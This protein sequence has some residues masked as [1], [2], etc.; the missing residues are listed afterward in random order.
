MTARRWLPGVLGLAALAAGGCADP[1][2]RCDAPQVAALAVA[3]RKLVGA[4]SPYP[5]DG[6]LR[7][8]EHE[9]ATSMAARRAA[10]WAAV[11]RVLEPVPFAIDPPSDVPAQ[12]P[13][14]QTWYGQ[15]DLHRM[16]QRLFRG[17][18]PDEQ[19]ARAP[20][21]DGALDEAF[22]WNPHAVDELDTWPAERWQAYVASLDTQAEVAGVGGI[23]RVAYSP[24]AAR[25]LMA[26]YAQALACKE[27]GTPP[28]IGDAPTAGPVRMA[29]ETMELGAC[30]ERSFGPYFVG[31]GETLTASVDGAATVELRASG[32]SPDVQA[33]PAGDPSC[34]DARCTAAGPAAVWLTVHATDRGAAALTVD[35]HEADPTWAP[36]LAAPFPLDAAVIKADWRRAE[37]GIL[38]PRFD[39]SADGLQRMID[40]ESTWGDGDAQLDPGP[41]EI[42]TLALPSNGARYR[43]T[44]LHLMTKELDHWLW[45][46]LW[47]SADPDHDFGADRPDAIAALPG[48]WRHYKMC[49]VTAFRDEDLDAAGGSA[50]ESLAKALAKVYT[51]GGASWCS[52]P[53]IELGHGNGESNC[54]GC[55]QHGGTTLDSA[56]IIGDED[57]F[58]DHA[59]GQERNNFPSDYSWAVSQGDHLGQMFADEVLFST[60]P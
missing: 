30:E 35:Y 39:T 41:D 37:L 4:A 58:P 55:H 57:H 34:D 33:P 54:I 56:T 18:T 60:P 10:A 21:T 2:P 16:F 59:R 14:W 50:D 45:I 26:S 44:A 17:L 46:T 53:Y 48:P 32:P 5:A 13:R 43:L 52:N 12:L 36:C 25:H 11:E 49:V 20:F 8:R 1:A 23:D 15:D 47:W 40:A 6:L 9:L 31:A 28:P 7:G 42:Y 22:A 51:A 38:A 3:D 24:G 27:H 19:R 29:R